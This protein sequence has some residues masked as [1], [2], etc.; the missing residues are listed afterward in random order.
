MQM[1][2]RRAYLWAE[3]GSIPNP[4]AL[5]AAALRRFFLIASNNC[6]NCALPPFPVPWLNV[7]E[8]LCVLT[9]VVGPVGPVWVVFDGLVKKKRERYKDSSKLTSFFLHYWMK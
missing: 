6:P 8:C 7:C 5:L 1:A 4:H 3:D 2:L 9:G